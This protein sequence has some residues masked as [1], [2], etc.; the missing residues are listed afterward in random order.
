M[1]GEERQR[2]FKL[3]PKLW[4]YLGGLGGLL[5]F[6]AISAWWDLTF[7]AFDVKAFVADTLILIAISLATM[8]LSDLLSEEANMN[9]ILGKYNIACNEYMKIMAAIEPIR[10]YFVQWFF[11]EKERETAAKREG[12]LTLHGFEG[13]DARKIVR[14]GEISDIPLMKGEKTYIKVLD[15]GTKVP[16]PRISTPEQEEAVR[17]VLGGEQDVKDVNYTEYLFIESESEANMAFLERQGY[18][19]RRRK[20]NKVKSYITRIVGIILTALL[21]AAL[22]PAGEEGGNTNKWWL[23][24]KRFGAFC[25]SLIWGWLAGANNVVARASKIQD[26]ADMQVR[27][28]DCYEKGLW[29]PKTQ[30]EIDAELIRQYEE[31]EEA[32]RQPVEDTAETE[33]QPILGGNANG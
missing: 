6:I 12:Y 4:F 28:R 5:A 18:L 8:V 3:S 27:F 23:F 31:S 21:M 14:Y 19:E 26:K 29:K 32:E 10:V 17:S 33:P 11:W 30:E 20:A 15:D 13:I 24:A 9:K 2:K 22:V 16:M 25:T 1:S 7:G